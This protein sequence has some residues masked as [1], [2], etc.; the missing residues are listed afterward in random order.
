[1]GKRTDHKKMW[2]K[3]KNENIKL[4]SEN[5]RLRDVIRGQVDTLTKI[6]D[7]E[8]KPKEL[9]AMKKAVPDAVL[10]AV[11]DQARERKENEK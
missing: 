3:V 8:I 1:M 11:L 6:R 4:Y 2:R 10:Q 9:M 7:G 5:E